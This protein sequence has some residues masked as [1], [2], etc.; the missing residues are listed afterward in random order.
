MD[1][2]AT[3]RRESEGR[4]KRYVATKY[5]LIDDRDTG[6]AIETVEAAKRLNALEAEVAGLREAG[7]H[8]WCCGCGHW[9]GP[10]L[11]TC[12]MCG[13]TPSEAIDS[14]REAAEKARPT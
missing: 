4:M 12:A 13:R 1:V 8:L 2:E 14:T 11:A 6:N 10:N 3:T 5:H 9:N 7:L